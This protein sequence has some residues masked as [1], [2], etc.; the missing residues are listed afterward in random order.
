MAHVSDLIAQD[1]EAYLHQHEH[2]SLLRFLTCGSVDDG[3]STLIGRLLYDS[4]DDLRGPARRARG[5]FEEGRHAGRRPRFRA[6]RRRPRGRARAGHHDRRRL[7]L[8]LHRPAQVHRRRHARARAVHAQHGDRRVDRRPRRD[9]DR[10]AQGRAHAD[11]PAQ[12]P[13]VAPGHPARSCSRSTRWTWSATRTRRLRRDRRGLP[14]VRAQIGFERRHVHPDLGAQ[15]RQRHRHASANMPWYDGPTLHGAPRD[16]S[17]SSDHATQRPFRLPVQ[18]VNRPN[19]DFRGFAGTIASGTV[20]KP[21][22]RA[23]A[24]VGSR[25]HASTRIVTMDGDLAQA[26]GGPV[27]H[28][29]ARRRDRRQP[30]RRPRPA[31]THL[32]GVAD[33][34]E[35]TVIWMRE[36]RC[37]P[38]D[39]T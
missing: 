13:R 25:E 1:I 5:G 39:R 19:L 17:R 35:A 33:Q 24:A 20:R 18:W 29:H 34:F 4:Q 2:K 9:P 10:R 16:A 6:A 8:L 30:R 11:T 14:R 32:P 26:I 12:L 36:S 3:K 15:G 31:A 37:C 23:R 21:A 28:P 7:S 38:G 27:G 22:T